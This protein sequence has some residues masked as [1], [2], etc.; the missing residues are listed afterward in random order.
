LEVELDFVITA[1]DVRSYKPDPRHF[2]AMLARTGL[3]REQHLHAAQSRY[4]DIAPA[5]LLGIPT[6]WVNRVSRPGPVITPHDTPA[7]PTLVVRDLTELAAM[8]GCPGP[9]GHLFQ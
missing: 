6:A 2:H 8:L 5:N 7:S 1:E 3:S 9:G 4:H